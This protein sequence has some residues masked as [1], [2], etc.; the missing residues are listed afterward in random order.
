MAHH[1]WSKSCVQIKNVIDNRSDCKKKIFKDRELVLFCR[2]K[3]EER[4]RVTLL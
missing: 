4:E 3:N 1:L 2:Y